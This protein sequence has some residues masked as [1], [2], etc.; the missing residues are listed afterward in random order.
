[1]AGWAVCFAGLL[2]HS[3]GSLCDKAAKI[4]FVAFD[5][6]LSHYSVSLRNSAL[7]YRIILIMK[8]ETMLPTKTH[9]IIVVHVLSR[10]DA[11]RSR[12]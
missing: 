3:R 8:I 1:M 4:R 6:Y 9:S 2:A 12:E 7:S 5:Q 11:P 10:G